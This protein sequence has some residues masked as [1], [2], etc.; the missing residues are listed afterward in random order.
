[1]S[2]TA[3]NASTLTYWPVR[4]EALRRSVAGLSSPDAPPT[5]LAQLQARAALLNAQLE[6]KK[7]E[8]QLASGN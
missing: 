7:L 3:T 4:S 8:G 5:E 1:V 6:I 2:R